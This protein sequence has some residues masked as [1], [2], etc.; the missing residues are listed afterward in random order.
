[1]RL[2]PTSGRATNAMRF[3]AVVSREWSLLGRVGGGLVVG[4]ARHAAVG[5]QDGGAQRVAGPKL[6]VPV[7][8]PFFF[9]FV[10]ADL[11]QDDVLAG[12]QL[13]AA[14]VLIHGAVGM[15]DVRHAQQFAV[16]P[17]LIGTLRAESQ[18]DR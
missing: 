17:D 1:M 9:L 5:R 3:E 18:L 6:E 11:Q 4:V 10:L 14:D 7:L 13:A 8:G 2:R 16:K 15:I 12:P